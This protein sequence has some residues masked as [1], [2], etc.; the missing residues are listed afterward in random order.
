MSAAL[1]GTMLCV[2]VHRTDA[3][4]ARSGPVPGGGLVPVHRGLL[5]EAPAVRE[6]PVLVHGAGGERVRVQLEPLE[7]AGGRRQPGAPVQ[8]DAQPTAPGR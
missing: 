3:A 6:A 8:G 7:P 5:A 1:S 2:C 4:A